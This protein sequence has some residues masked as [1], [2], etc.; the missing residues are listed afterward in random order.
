MRESGFAV[1]ALRKQ[2]DE[3]VYFPFSVNFPPWLR[4]AQWFQVLR[5]V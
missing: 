3:I 4:P 5:F 1:V 2:K